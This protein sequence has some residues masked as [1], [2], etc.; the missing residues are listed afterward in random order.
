MA[1][2][3]GRA[4]TLCRSNIYSNHMR[5]RQS[6]PEALRSSIAGAC[7]MLEGNIDDD[8][9]KSK[10]SSK[11]GV[12]LFNK[13]NGMQLHSFNVVGREPTLSS[14]AR[15]SLPPSAFVHFKH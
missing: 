11:I 2:N 14:A 1:N 9:V 13:C 15:Y 10:S 6:G 4:A 7:A 12:G 8:D 5:A 3:L